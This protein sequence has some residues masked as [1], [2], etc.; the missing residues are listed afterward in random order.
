LRERVT[1]LR[2]DFGG[3]PVFHVTKNFSGCYS[4]SRGGETKHDGKKS[5]YIKN[6]SYDVQ[7]SKAID[8]NDF[9]GGDF[10]GQL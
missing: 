3:K 10:F 1:S 9:F 6:V 7:F 5:F 2:R 4:K 8:S